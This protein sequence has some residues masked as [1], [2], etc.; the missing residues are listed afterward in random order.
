MK[1]G[2]KHLGK[3][4]R[5]RFAPSPTGYLHIGN[6]HTAL[7]NWL[8]AR[9]FGG[10][11]VLRIEDT[12][13]ARSRADYEGAIVED[14]RWLGLDWDEGVDVGGPYGPYRQSERLAIYRDAAQRLLSE[15][16]LYEC[17][18][19]D[20]EMAED[21]KRYLDQG[22]MPRYSG[23]CRNL[24][25]EERRRLAAEGRK[26]ALR[27][28]VPAGEEIVLQD[29]IRGEISFATDNIGDFIVLRSNGM[30][31]YNFSVTVDD[32]LMKITHIIRGDEHISNTPR[33]ILLYRALGEEEPQFAHIAMLLG[34]DR[35]KL[36]KRHGA[37]S[38]GD[39]RRM[40]F[41]PEALVNYLALLGWSS[42][43]GEEILPL[44]E[45]K[46]QFTLDRVAKSPAI[47]D[48]AKLRWMNAQYINKLMPKELAALARAFLP[49][50]KEDWPKLEQVMAVL[51]DELEVLGDLW[52]RVQLFYELPEKDGQAAKILSR[53]ET[54]AILTAFQ[55][56]LR[57]VP[58]DLTPEEAGELLHGLPPKL[59]L[60][61]G[62]V[63]RSIR[64]ALTGAASGP[65]LVQIIAILGRDECLR[66]VRLV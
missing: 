62:K 43:T 35:S 7:F 40:G 44:P 2:V 14:L 51:Q 30:P 49:E 29:L 56:A 23:R 38:I 32:A 21:R 66:R 28:K 20:E 26:P 53:P 54:G 36:S 31:V 39:F 64:A 61:T 48:I 15:G 41:L 11:V 57:G 10:Q 24:S 6:V 37:A 47:F 59:G 42:P 17:Y 25:D 63:L 13:Q 18:C 5:V 33:Q 1:A 34:P 60:G 12:D 8:F 65:E 45:I 3:T 22:L 50:E 19:T 55:E 52:P 58:E 9:H 27:F 46:A 16:F 4:V